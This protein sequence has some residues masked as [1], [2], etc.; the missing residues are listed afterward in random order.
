MRW[1]AR[2]GLNNAPLWE[3]AGCHKGE[4]SPRAG[5]GASCCWVAQKGGRRFLAFVGGGIRGRISLPVI[6][7]EGWWTV[8]YTYLTT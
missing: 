2:R 4:A 8:L 3:S 1:G 5:S 6:G 7:G